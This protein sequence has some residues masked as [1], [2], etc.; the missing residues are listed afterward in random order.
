M[1]VPTK[2]LF[3]DWIVSNPIFL[4]LSSRKFLCKKRKEREREETWNTVLRV[5]AHWIETSGMR[6][7]SFLGRRPFLEAS[8]GRERV[9]I[10]QLFHS[11]RSLF[12]PAVWV[13]VD[14]GEED[15]H[16]WAQ[17]EIVILTNDRD[18]GKW[19]RNP[20]N[21]RE[22]S[23]PNGQCSGITWQLLIRRLK[24]ENECKIGF[25]RGY[26]G[27]PAGYDFLFVLAFAKCP[28]P[29]NANILLLHVWLCHFFFRCV[30]SILMRTG[31][32]SMSL[33]IHERRKHRE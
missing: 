20:E 14:D 25:K 18:G 4:L 29:W 28:L 12:V 30:H 10:G 9:K 32:C 15:M 24:K 33:V 26:K 23:S 6:R 22:P 3:S 7:A 16:S 27:E 17:K 19:R 13:R 21:A 11:W 1:S 8:L 5:R 31:C 2:I